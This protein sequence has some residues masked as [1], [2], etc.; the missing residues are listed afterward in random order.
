MDRTTT[1][2]RKSLS[3][4]GLI[5]FSAAAGFALITLPVELDASR[6]ALVMLSSH[7]ILDAQELPG[8]QK[9]LR[10]AAMTYV[11]AALQTLG[12]LLYYVSIFAGRRR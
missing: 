8:A 12:T 6:R 11:A 9:V 3:F 10:A 7:G 4:I 2:P 5:A 1:L